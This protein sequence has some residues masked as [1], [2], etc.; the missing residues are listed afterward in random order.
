MYIVQG[1]IYWK[2]PPPPEGGILADFLGEKYEKGEEDMGKHLKEKGNI[3]D[4][5]AKNMPKGKKRAL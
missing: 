5:R 1:C 4:E 2:Y 3:E